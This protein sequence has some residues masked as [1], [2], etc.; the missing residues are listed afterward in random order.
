MLHDWEFAARSAGRSRE[1]VSCGGEVVFALFGL[2]QVA[3]L[4]DGFPEFIDCSDSPGAQM[5]FEF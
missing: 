2:E 3:D 1:S 5:R 4:S